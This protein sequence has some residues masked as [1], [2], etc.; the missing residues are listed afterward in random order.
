MNPTQSGYSLIEILIVLVIISGIGAIAGPP[1]A[2]LYDRIAFSL[3]RE[4]VE[5][6]IA[7]LPMQA[8]LAGQTLTLRD[9][10]KK[11]DAGSE[12]LEIA[13]DEQSATIILPAGWALSVKSPI[14][15][16]FDGLCL[17]GEIQIDAASQ[18]TRYRLEP[19][20]CRLQAIP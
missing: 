3:A 12:K 1:M 5:R 13:D 19:P 8:R 7:N 17:G 18:H 6:E 15:Y 10:P 14:I 4:D 16:R 9:Q 20:F 2:H 11:K